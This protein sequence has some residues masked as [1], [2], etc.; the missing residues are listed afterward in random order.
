[1][2]WWQQDF[3]GD[4]G[5]P[6]S[7]DAGAD[8]PSWLEVRPDGSELLVYGEITAQRTDFFEDFE[9]RSALCCCADVLRAFDRPVGFADLE[10]RLAD[11][12]YRDA[13]DLSVAGMA[14]VLELNGV[15]AR[16]EVG[17][18]LE[19]LAAHAEQGR[20]CVIAVD[21]GVWWNE[22]AH[23]G[24]GAA[25]LPL[26]L[27]ASARDPASGDL[28]GFYFNDPAS[29]RDGVYGD[30]AVVSRSWLETGAQMV[31]TEVIKT[32]VGDLLEGIFG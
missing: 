10:A 28:R 18:S 24:F 8:V 30:T 19:D 4:A 6:P 7:A 13:S 23:W 29:G 3:G 26:T 5:E 2:T 25:N 32:W 15:S 1:M 20:G 17:L 16:A 27:T 9:A 21:A 11:T 12:P 22:P 14:A 31:F